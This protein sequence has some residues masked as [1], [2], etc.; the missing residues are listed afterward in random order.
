MVQQRG[1]SIPE[2]YTNIHKNI[3]SKNQFI[4]KRWRVECMNSNTEIKNHETSRFM[5]QIIVTVELR[6]K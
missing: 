4:K 2:T 6:Q 5:L 3:P 1:G